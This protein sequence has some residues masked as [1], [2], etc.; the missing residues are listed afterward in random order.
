MNG[1]KNTS[2]NSSLWQ[3][4]ISF[5]YLLI[6]PVLLFWLSGDWSWAEGWI[7][8]I[9]FCSLSFA[10]VL[11]L[12][13][14]DSALLNE[15]FGSPFQK[16]QKS[17]DKTL[18]VFVMLG[19]FVWFVVMPLDA[20]RFGWSPPFPLWL[21]II[22]TV[23]F[24]AGF[25]ILFAALK[26]NTFAAPVVKIQKERGQKVI[27]TGV[28][29]VVR[30]PMYLGGLLIFAGVPLLLGSIYGLAAGFLLILILAF[31]SIGEEKMLM[32][33]LD[34]YHEYRKKVRWR[35]IPFIFKF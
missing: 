13:F 22:G 9:G 14:K 34:G 16:E 28:Y 12:Y 33:E 25:V 3:V 23:L 1:T 27:S 5:F 4:I 2:A 15:R 35:L 32:Q 7:F 6:Y 17:W 21:K 29:G 8:S 30:H 10:I 24:V 26:E 19:F 18:L 11:Y 31:R 20:K